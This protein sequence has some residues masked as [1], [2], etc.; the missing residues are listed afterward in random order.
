M[1]GR[2]KTAKE[3][4]SKIS[5][6][7]LMGTAPAPYRPYHPAY[8][9][10]DWRGW[11]DFG[12]GALGDMGCH[13]IDAAFWALKLGHPA[14]VEASYV[15]GNDETG[16]LASIIYYQFPA[17]GDMP[18]VKLT[19]YDGGLRPPMPREHRGN[20]RVGMID[21]GLLF[22]GDEGRL[23]C[24]EYGGSPR[25]I[26]E[27][28]MKAYERPAKEIPRSIGHYKEWVEACKGSK[29]AGANFNYAG[30]LTEVVLLGNI[31]I[32]AG[33]KKLYWDGQRMEFTN[34]DEANEY[35]RRGYREGWSL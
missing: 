20:W 7:D 5:R 27:A 3:E 6:R 8:V 21:D 16:P 12:T 29:P 31:A 24:S 15:G 17:R 2:K 30:P 4:E 32:R 25:L 19:W 1:K 11:W 18:P 33:R 13:T 23:K 9:P 14:S 26:P 10:R 34:Y 22:V 35:I 28:K